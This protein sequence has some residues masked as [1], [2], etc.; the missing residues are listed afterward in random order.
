VTSFLLVGSLASL[1]WPS[2]A[3][4]LILAGLTMACLRVK[5]RFPEIA[6]AGRVPAVLA[7]VVIGYFGVAMSAFGL[8]AT[9]SAYFPVPGGAAWEGPVAVVGGM[10]AF[11]IGACTLLEHLV[12]VRSARGRETV[13][14]VLAK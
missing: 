2:L 5:A 12:R 6:A 9:T 4:V 14:P 10:A 8:S 13:G 11:T 3:W 1:D 7:H